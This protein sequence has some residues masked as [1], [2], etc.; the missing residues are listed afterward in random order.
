MCEYSVN[1]VSFCI[2]YQND[3]ISS[4]VFGDFFANKCKNQKSR[5]RAAFVIELA[6]QFIRKTNNINIIEYFFN[7]G[8]IKGIIYDIC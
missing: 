5:P 4:S 1:I 3:V 8:F 7:I 2:L 6:F